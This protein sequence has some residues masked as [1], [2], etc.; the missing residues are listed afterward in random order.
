VFDLVG[1]GH[2]GPALISAARQAFS[3]DN[4]GVA[5]G[6]ISKFGTLEMTVPRVRRPIAEDLLDEAGAPTA[7][8]SALRLIRA[9]E[10]EGRA[11]PGARLIGRC[12]AACAAAFAGLAGELAARLGARFGIESPAGWPAGRLEVSAR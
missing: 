9:L 10:R 2:D 1:R 11:A 8:T 7:L 5:I 4:P 3:L 6:P 12:D